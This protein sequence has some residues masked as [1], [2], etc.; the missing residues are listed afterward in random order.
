M[1]AI[2]F[3]R[4]IAQLLGGSD[5]DVAFRD[6]QRIFGVADAVQF[7]FVVREGG[8]VLVRRQRGGSSLVL[9]RVAPGG[10]L[11]EASLFAQRY[12]CEAVACGPTLL[13]RIPRSRVV[14]E[15]LG[16]PSWLRDFAAHLA[17]EVQR[18]RARAELLSL[19]KVDERVDAWLALHG[20]A[21]PGRGQWIDW[22]SELG[23]TPE[24]LYRELARRR[25]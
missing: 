2:M 4:H 3:P 17:S 12:H 15:Q 9:Q 1:I 16:D 18:A 24:A 7:L 13:A 8:V 5:R 23:I 21:M 6:G 19:K 14:D 10:L 22:A 25:A 11:A 20:K